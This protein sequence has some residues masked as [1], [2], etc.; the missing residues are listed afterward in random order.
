MSSYAKKETHRSAKPKASEPE[1]DPFYDF[2][3][4]I[5]KKR[6][7]REGEG[8]SCKNQGIISI[9][10][11]V[12]DRHFWYGMSGMYRFKTDMGLKAEDR[13]CN[14]CLK[15]QKNNI[16]AAKTVVCTNCG[17]KFQP[18]FERLDRDGYDCNCDVH[19]KDGVLR[20]S[21]GYGSK[22]DV[23]T[24]DVKVPVVKVG[25]QVCDKCVDQFVEEGSLVENKDLSGF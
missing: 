9:G 20:V 16:E 6:M 2:D 11:M 13:I 8:E 7:T 15:A 12:D 1:I 14:D 25:D 3:C 10:H 21:C 4:G 19:A 17:E 18:V 24:F 5:C 22:H 23:T